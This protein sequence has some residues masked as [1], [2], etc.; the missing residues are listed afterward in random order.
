M[1]VCIWFG[2]CCIFLLSSII[3]FKVQFS[4][5]SRPLAYRTQAPNRLCKSAT[6]CQCIWPSRQRQRMLPQLCK[7]RNK[8]R[9]HPR[10]QRTNQNVSAILWIYI[11]LEVYSTASYPFNTRAAWQPTLLTGVWYGRCL[12]SVQ[13]AAPAPN[14]I[15]HSIARENRREDYRL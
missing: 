15:P 5:H 8:S 7:D 14:T 10:G 6:S 12:V 3:I 11:Y 4:A 13:N 1:L 9:V 2:L